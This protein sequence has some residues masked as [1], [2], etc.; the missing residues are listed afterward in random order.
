MMS[1]ACA[2]ALLGATSKTSFP[3]V[4]ASSCAQRP[5]DALKL[6]GTADSETGQMAVCCQNLPVRALSSRSAV[7]VLVGALF[8]KFDLFLNTLLSLSL[9]VS[10]RNRALHVTKTNHKKTTCTDDGVARRTAVRTVACRSAN[11]T[12]RSRVCPVQR[13]RLYIVEIT[14]LVADPS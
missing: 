3:S 1:D 10:L 7:T 6:P 13:H 4:Q 8:Q 5:S 14:A 2:G 9:S 12:S 11:T